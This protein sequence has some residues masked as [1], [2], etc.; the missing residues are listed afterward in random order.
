MIGRPTNRPTISQKLENKMELIAEV[1][2]N[3]GNDSEMAQKISNLDAKSDFHNIHVRYLI[4]TTNA[5]RL[6]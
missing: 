2:E 5:D 4:N 3:R 6:G 1:A